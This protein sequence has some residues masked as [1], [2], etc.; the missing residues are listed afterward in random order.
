MSNQLKI[1]EKYQN[2]IWDWNGTL[3][4]DNRLC[5]EIV[6][7]M[8]K[9]HSDFH[10]DLETYRNVFGFPIEDYYKKIG[11]DFQKESFEEL[12]IKFISNYD[13][14]VKDCNLHDA[15]ANTLRSFRK[16]ELNQFILTA[17]HKESVLELL[18]HYSIIDHFVEVEGLDNH[19]G[20]S[21][22]DRGIHLVQ[23]NEIRRETT[24][25]IGD[26]DHDYE[27]AQE[28]GIDCILIA[29]GHQSRSKLESKTKGKVR[30]LDNMEELVL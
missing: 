8:L 30:V 5:V 10:L 1:T 16:A 7:D 20:E 28:M 13:R 11:M 24:V 9:H 22:V 12:T 15:T 19:R 4:N 29:N 23:K 3:L 6:S 17:A 25:L 21:K 14:K 26:T 2:I 27:V 18:D